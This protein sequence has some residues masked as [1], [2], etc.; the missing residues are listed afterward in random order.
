VVPYREEDRR[1]A[2]GIVIKVG[3]HSYPVELNE[4][5]EQ[6]PLTREEIVAWRRRAQLGHDGRVSESPPAQLWRRRGT[7]RLR[8]ALPNG[9][10]GGR[11]SWCD[12]P[13]GLLEAR[14]IRS[15]APSSSALSPMTWR[16][17]SERGALGSCGGNRRCEMRVP[18]SSPSR[19]PASSGFSARSRR[20]A[21]PRPSAPTLPCCGAP[22]GSLGPVGEPVLGPPRWY[23]RLFE[24]EH[25]T[26]RAALAHRTVIQPQARRRCRAGSHHLGPSQVPRIAGGSVGTSVQGRSYSPLANA[27]LGTGLVPAFVSE[28]MDQKK[29]PGLPGLS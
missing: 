28:A 26:R 13:R 18:G 24:P 14:S 22:S 29:K 7:G 2:R 5:T 10:R 3:D 15:S 20:G 16:R 8:L 23:T 17:P 9:Y 27:I 1:G 19:P 4:L 6:L 12:G 11:A 25:I 21:G